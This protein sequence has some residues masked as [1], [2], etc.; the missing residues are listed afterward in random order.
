VVCLREELG[1]V[2]WRVF[3]G[4]MVVVYLCMLWFWCCLCCCIFGCVWFLVVFWLLY[5]CVCCGFFF[6][7]VQFFLFSSCSGFY[8][9]FVWFFFSSCGVGFYISCGCRCGILVYIVSKICSFCCFADECF[10][11]GIWILVKLCL[12]SWS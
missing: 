4:E 6:H 5:I 12:R 11:V 9:V 8:W 1:G 3:F 2:C 7:F 10:I